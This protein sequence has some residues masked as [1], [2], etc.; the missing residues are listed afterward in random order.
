ME[1]RILGKTGLKIS[2]MGFGGIPIQK[3]DEEGTRK[4]LHEMMEMGVNYIDSARGYTVSEQYIG[5]GLEGIR[6]KFVLAT[7]SMSR[8]KEAMA[9][10]IETSLG[11]FR[12]DYIDLYQVHNPSMEQLDQVI[13]E[14]GALEALM[15]AK[16]AGKIGHIGLTA[17]STAVFERALGLDWVETIMFPYNIVEQQGAEL[18]HKCAEKNIGFIDMKP[19]AGGAI[20]DA[21]LALRYVCSNPDVTVVIPGMAEVRELE[22]NLAACSNTEPL[23]DEELKAMDK[24][25]EQLGTDFCRRCNYCAPC[26]VGINIPSVFLFAGYLQRYDLADWAKDRYSTLKVKASA[27]I[28]CGKCEPR[29]PYHLPIREKLKKCAQDMGE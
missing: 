22:Q 28:G 26:T 8:T 20:E 24:V 16:A 14:G 12:T 10:D 25:R 7:K 15:E 29:C 1:Y 23:A 18:I 21:T 27:C 13:G 5:Y 2:R 4:L 9:A 11:N 6:D 19:L 3:I 17:H